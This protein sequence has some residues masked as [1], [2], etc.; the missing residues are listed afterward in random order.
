MKRQLTSITSKFVLGILLL[1]GV[2]AAQ[3][4]SI[5]K[6]SESEPAVVKYLGV[7]EDLVLF[8][9]HFKNPGGQKFSVIVKDQDNT[10][11]FQ[12][13]YTDKNFDKQFKLPRADRNRITFVIRNF[14]GEDISQ[15]FA[16]NVNTRYIEDI[17]IKKVD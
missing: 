4:Q 14:K 8:N 9:V 15:H 10:Q 17:A 6:V 5:D 12:R 11:L 3:G 1:T 2:F 16:I 7:Q 13:V